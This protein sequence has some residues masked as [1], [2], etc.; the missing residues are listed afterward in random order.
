MVQCPSANELK[1]QLQRH[2]SESS[3]VDDNFRKSSRRSSALPLSMAKQH[4]ALDRLLG[5][6]IM[7]RLLSDRDSI[8]KPLRSSQSYRIRKATTEEYS[9]LSGL[10]HIENGQESVNLRYNQS[11]NSSDGSP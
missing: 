2:G 8:N 1:Y 11:V 5:D 3:R 6:Q 10:N 4:S 9:N 7:N